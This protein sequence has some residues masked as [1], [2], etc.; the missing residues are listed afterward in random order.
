MPEFTSHQPGT[1][2]WIE[3]ATTDAEAA[4]RFYTG[5]FDWTFND[6]PMGPSMTYTI[7]QKGGRDVAAAY[8]MGPEMAGMPP[9]WLSY[10]SV[11]SAD[12]SAAK[13]ATLGANVIKEPF[14]VMD[15]GRMAVMMDP[16]GGAF[17]IWEPNAHIGVGRRDEPGTL[18]WNELQAKDPGKAKAF[19][20]ALFGWTVKDS[21]EYTE[22][23]VGD[24]GI[25][26]MMQSQAGPE[27]P[28]FWLPY[29]AVDDADSAVA[30]AKA[31]GGTA[32]M[33]PMDYP[34]VG[35]F[36]LLADPQGAVFAV[37]KLQG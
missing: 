4:K 6:Y 18:C 2:S 10:I 25:G 15:N 7:F 31:G 33:E 30:K 36:S 17:A 12:D 32:I 29:F 23:H 9:N 27:V 14:D 22:W 13:A 16:Q 26:G 20:P 1:F 28:S 35:R 3:L 24:K 8:T 34:G 5:I 37:I 19:Y 11:A 21:P